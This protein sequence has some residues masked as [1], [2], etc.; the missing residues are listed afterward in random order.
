MVPWRYGISLFLFNS[1]CHKWAQRTSE[2]LSW[3][4]KEKFPIAN[5][6]M[7][8]RLLCISVTVCRIVYLW[9]QELH[10]NSEWWWVWFRASIKE[11]LWDIY[12][13]WV[14]SYYVCVRWTRKFGMEQVGKGQVTNVKITKLSFRALVVRR[15]LPITLRRW[16]FER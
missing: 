1:I 7:R 8:F 6:I 12:R 11:T 13:S 2:I 14:E 5:M 16:R 9:A 3:T 10:L 4:R 15:H